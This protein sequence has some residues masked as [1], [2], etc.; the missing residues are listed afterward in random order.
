MSLKRQAVGPDEAV[1]FLSAPVLL[2]GTSGVD[3]VTTPA[4]RRFQLHASAATG[5]TDSLGAIIGRAVVLAIAWDSFQF[6]RR[7]SADA[8]DSRSLL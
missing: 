8:K 7:Y 4:R 5:V 6:V 2:R 1:E 3:A